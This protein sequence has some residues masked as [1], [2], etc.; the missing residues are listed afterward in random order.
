ML[1]PASC[2]ESMAMF[3]N[4]DRRRNMQTTNG[5]NGANLAGINKDCI[6]MN[7]HL[8]R[9]HDPAVTVGGSGT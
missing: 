8:G 4:R 7:L 9:D 2:G 5:P 6:G 1:P 3:L